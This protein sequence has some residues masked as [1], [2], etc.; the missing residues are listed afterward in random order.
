MLIVWLLTPAD[1]NVEHVG[2]AHGGTDAKLSLEMQGVDDTPLAYV[3]YLE[4]S[5]RS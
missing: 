2:Q 1:E 3:T 5:Q 4:V